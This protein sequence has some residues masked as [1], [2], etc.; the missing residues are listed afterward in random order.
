MKAVFLS[1][2]AHDLFAG[3]IAAVG[4]TRSLQEI[5]AHL[6]KN[7]EMQQEV[8]QQIEMFLFKCKS[9]LPAFSFI[10]YNTDHF[11]AVGPVSEGRM[12]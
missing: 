5:A 1:I 4:T 2:K 6:D 9:R 11:C 7:Q 3:F 12:G 10:R 8:S